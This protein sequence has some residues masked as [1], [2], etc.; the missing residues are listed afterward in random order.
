[1]SLTTVAFV[2]L[3]FGGLILA[4]YK[5]IY[6]L[7]TYVWTFYNNPTISWWGE[8]LPDLRWSLLAAV[9]T[10]LALLFSRMRAPADEFRPGLFSS[11]GARLMVLFVAWFWLMSLWA[12][13]PVRQSDGVMLVTKFAILFVLIT[14]ILTEPRSLELFAWTHVLGA[15]TWGWMAYRTDVHGRF[16]P[17][18]GP[19][20]NDANELGFQII[21]ALAFAGY[22]VIGFRGWKRY[23]ALFTVPFLLNVVILTASRSALIG[24]IAAG[25]VGVVSTP[26][27][28]RRAVMVCAALGAVLFLRLAGSEVFWQRAATIGQTDTAEMD[29]SAAARVIV[30]Q[31]NWRMFLDYPMGAGFRG[32][33]ALSPRY[34]PAGVLTEGARG[35]HNT[36]LAALVDTGVPGTTLLVMMLAWGAVALARVTIED[37]AT[38]PPVA[39]YKPAVA[40]CLA[41]YCI[42][43]QFLNLLTAEVW[44]WILALV[45]VLQHLSSVRAASDGTPQPAAP[46]PP[47]LSAAALPSYDFTLHNR[48]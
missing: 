35:A 47:P 12:V 9:V 13:D 33:A 1:M 14:G 38:G 7:C 21:T 6:G 24:L 40:A 10:L 41:A 25:V 48:S 17:M 5:P 29:D 44:V 34:M 3:Y 23:L 15:F 30:A 31:A 16:E 37:Q 8:M 18:L 42:C 36:F 32:N 22:M 26:K 39:F 2:I 11:W 19:G 27:R 43:G 46:P 20:M 28:H 45:P 4:F